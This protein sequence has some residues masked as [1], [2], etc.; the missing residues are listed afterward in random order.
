V[1]LR[2]D[3][4]VE[5]ANEVGT[6]A[7]HPPFARTAMFNWTR[8][9]FTVAACG[10][11][12]AASSFRVSRV[13]RKEFIASKM[14]AENKE[15]AVMMRI[16]PVV[17]VLIESLAMTGCEMNATRVGQ[18]A[19]VQFG[20]VRAAQEIEL[21]SNAAQGALVGGTLGL[22]SGR[23]GGAGPSGR[24]ARNAIVGAAAG[25][26]MTAASE[27]DRRGT[28]YTV[29]MMDGSST[30]IVTDQR[31]IREGDCV[32]IERVGNTANIRRA[33]ASYCDNANQQAVR[34]VDSHTSSDALGCEIA[35][36][37]LVDATTDEAVDLA[38]R[39]IDLLC[40]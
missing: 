2:S 11:I 14:T 5:V 8:A 28:Q 19:T 18:T 6:P 36:Q 40:S 25:G 35:K 34:S 13:A 7:A 27:G 23:A 22:M 1:K 38:K 9:Q 10:L 39:K 30:R 26:A 12:V 16:L 4:V 29:E 15:H 33:S 32:A 17:A 37:E 31:E 3:E 24:R 21:N 20:V